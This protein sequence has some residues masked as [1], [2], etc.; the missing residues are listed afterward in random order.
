[1]SAERLDEA[2][3]AARTAGLRWSRDGDSLVTTRRFDGFPA[4]V[5]FVVRVAFLAEQRRHHP[6]ITISYNRVGLR[7]T[8]HDAGGITAAD[9][10]LAA[11]VDALEAGATGAG[12]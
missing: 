11:A 1:M 5:A 3:I 4:A 6:D 9:V 10:D 8:T 12:D 2:A 7:L